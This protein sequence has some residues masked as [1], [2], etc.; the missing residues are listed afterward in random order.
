MLQPHST[1]EM[2][3]SVKCY[4]HQ[5]QMLVK[6]LSRQCGKS[7]RKGSK[8]QKPRC[9]TSSEGPNSTEVLKERQQ[10]KMKRM[11]MILAM[12][13]ACF[14]DKTLELVFRK[15]KFFFYK[16][17]IFSASTHCR[18]LKFL[19]FIHACVLNMPELL[20]LNLVRI[21]SMLLRSVCCKMQKKNL[22]LQKNLYLIQ[23]TEYFKNNEFSS[24]PW[25]IGISCKNFTILFRI[26]Y[27]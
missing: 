13:Q 22:T 10:W 6:T 12:V 9:L 16:G 2:I 24:K 20:F 26:V 1:R 11:K 5:V 27:E 23:L 25:H 17:N 19:G 14:D 21:L 8:M 7:T 4:S 15:L 18:E 3:Q